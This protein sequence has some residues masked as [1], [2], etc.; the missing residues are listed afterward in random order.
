M[1]SSFLV[2]FFLV[3]SVIVSARAQSTPQ[4]TSTR[5]ARI[6]DT[7]VRPSR[8]VVT[9]SIPQPKANTAQAL[10]QSTP[11]KQSRVVVTESLP[12][13]RVIAAPVLPPQPRTEKDDAE[14]L[15]DADDAPSKTAPVRYIPP[16]TNVRSLSFGEIKSK[17]A[18]A[19]R[20]MMARPMQTASPDPSLV[21][22]YVRIAFY[23]WTTHRVD[24]VVMNKDSFLAKSGSTQTLSNSG[25]S[26]TV[27]N[28]RA[29]G[30][31]TPITL[32]DN[33]GQAHLP[34]IVQ[35]PVEKGGRFIETAYYM[36]THP[37]LVTPEVVGAGK[38]YVRNVIEVARQKLRERGVGIDPK[39]ADMAER[40]A[41]V[42]HVDHQRF[43]TEPSQNIFNDIFTLYALNEG[44]TYRYSVSSAGA[45]GMV[46]MIPATY[47]MMRRRYPMVNLN[48]DFVE[49]MR[50]HVNA[51]QAMLLYM[52]MTWNDLVASPTISDALT[53]GVATPPQLMAAGYNSNP[54]KLAGYINRG[55][56]R[57]TSLIPRETQIYL[58]I[59][60]SLERSVQMAPR[61]Q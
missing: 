38:L 30:V 42:E 35:Y 55:G 50:N 22:S 48:P 41:T 33:T 40:L 6:V 56:E 23:D 8:V 29:N 27:T 58:Q 1:R 31:N 24:Y 10:P 44:Q 17:I 39:V 53:N 19:R 49:G 43:R 34:L 11:V 52:Q 12:P 45:G 61:K 59:W 7:E 51:S 4:P 54:A 21:T 57:W 18:E 60:D 26:L 3:L 16:V 36:S 37:G 15:A 28:I 25:K 2:S 20:D 32:V 47:Q 13:T 5:P 9:D 46:Q 14:V